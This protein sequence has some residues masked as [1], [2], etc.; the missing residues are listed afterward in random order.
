MATY[1]YHNSLENKEIVD[2]I[3]KTSR[4]SYSEEIFSW[5]YKH[6]K[7]SIHCIQKENQLLGSQGMIFMELKLAQKS[8]N[9][10]KSETTFVDNSLRGKGQFESLYDYCVN[11]TLRKESQLIW[12][13]TALGTLWEKKLHF[14]CNKN[15]IFEANLIVHQSP[16]IKGFK[17][18]YYFLKGIQNRIKRM[19]IS[20]KNLSLEDFN[21]SSEILILKQFDS[22]F[23]D[24]TIALDYLSETVQN[25]IFHSPVITYK[26]LKIHFL[27]N[28]EAIIIYHI[29]KNQFIISDF[30]YLNKDKLASIV[31]KVISYSLIQKN[32]TNIRF[33][34]NKENEHY[35][36]I[37]DTFSKFGS[38]IILVN[39]MQLVYKPIDEKLKEIDPSNYMI[40]GLWTEG[41]TY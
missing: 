7:S 27:G 23:S 24:K 18:I 32:I 14:K 22:I 5:Q 40:N 12:G 31:K 37:F 28:L 38:N 9:S 19:A 35:S 39:D 26:Y 10:H 33:W 17:R 2:F 4:P 1:T 11:E 21:L 8:L 3:K 6:P 20:E 16:A 13:F 34:G 30:L 36:P 41:F 25:R 29:A 15:L